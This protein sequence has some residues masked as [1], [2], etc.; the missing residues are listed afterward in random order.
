MIENSLISHVSDT[1]LM[2]A[3]CRAMETARE[4]GMVRDPFAERLA[5]IRGMEIARSLSNTD[6]MCFGVGMRSR[7]LDDLLLELIG[8]GSIETVVHLGAG[9]DTRPWRLRLPETLRWIEID[10]PGILNYKISQMSG[11]TASCFLEQ[12]AVDLNS[13]NERRGLF[14]RLGQSPSLILA[15][16]VLPYLPEA[17]V[18]DLINETAE[19]RGCQFFMLDVTSPAFAR[20]SDT[21]RSIKHVRDETSLQGQ[22]IFSR[23]LHRGWT[24]RR[25]KSYIADIM[26]IAGKRVLKALRERAARGPTEPLPRDDI[27]GVYLLERQ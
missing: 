1:A 22:E 6:V 8:S 21:M 15:E 19:K 13:V 10:L 5:G 7:F 9:L 4:D 14:D 27:S 12:L 2:V 20:R 16:G 11:E 17:A 23:F 24:V 26:E 3:A 18:Q 25:R